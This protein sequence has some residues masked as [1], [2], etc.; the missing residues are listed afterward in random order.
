MT[1]SGGE[2]CL[3]KWEEILCITGDRNSVQPYF[4]YPLALIDTNRSI[5]GAIQFNGEDIFYMSSH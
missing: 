4:T 5:L 2:K 1:T 3:V